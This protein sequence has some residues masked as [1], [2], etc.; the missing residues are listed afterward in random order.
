MI[1]NLITLNSVPYTI[2]HMTTK[3][4][5]AF[6]YIFAGKA[7]F[8]LVSTKM[9]WRYTYKITQM[10]SNKGKYIVK[11]LYGSDNTED[12]KYLGILDRR[13]LSLES[14]NIES[15]QI[16]LLMLFIHMLLNSSM[17]WPETC[18]FHKSDKCAACGRLLTT[19][20]SIKLG[21]GPRCYEALFGPKG[22]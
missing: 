7:I 2:C 11:V 3:K 16:R 1:I 20:E 22:E 5:E 19:P 8:T 4:H 13:L 18:E 15:G 12:Y 6:D 21:Y 10:K 17:E 14:Y 9:S